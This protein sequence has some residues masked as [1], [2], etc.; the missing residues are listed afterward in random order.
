M[1]IQDLGALGEVVG[2]VAILVTLAYLAIQ[3]RYAK[4]AV[5]DQSRQNRA[6][7]LRE[8]NGRFVDNPELRRAFNEV[9]NPEWRRML[10]DLA[11]A[12]GVSVDDASLIFWSQ[13]DYIWTHW[14]Q[15]H[16]QKTVEDARELE[17]IVSTWY[18]A[19]PMQTIIEHEAVKSSFDPE[20]IRWVDSI[21]ASESRRADR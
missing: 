18:S 3:I 1:N 5:T 7:A 20:F 12:W 4:I 8:I 2:A 6:T 13:N 21:L 11:S 14:A 15:Y 19:P 9:A 17:N 16:S 10:E